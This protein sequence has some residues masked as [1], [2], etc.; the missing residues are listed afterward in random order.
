MYNTKIICT[1]NY[2]DSSLKHLN[3]QEID[4]E[5]VKEFQDSDDIS[6]I[7]YRSELLSVFGLKEYDNDHVNSILHVIYEKLKKIEEMKEIFINLASLFLN[8]DPDIGFMVLF[9]YHY[10]FL[11]HPCVCEL[12]ETNTISLDKINKLKGVIE[13]HHKIQEEKTK[14]EESVKEES[15]NL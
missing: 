12:E 1:Y 9:S 6:G 13:N 8:D 15:T 10:F 3:S 2:Y 7:L 14:R 4:E 11:M 5:L